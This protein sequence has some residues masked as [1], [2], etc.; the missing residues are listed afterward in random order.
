MSFY[1]DIPP[2]YT[3]RSEHIVWNMTNASEEEQRKMLALLSGE[4]T[5]PKK[6]EVFVHDSCEYCGKHRNVSLIP[7]QHGWSWYCFWCQVRYLWRSRKHRK[8]IY[9]RVTQARR[10]Q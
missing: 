6:L 1:N 3:G 2:A 10:K 8:D 5:G 9:K 4:V 7:M